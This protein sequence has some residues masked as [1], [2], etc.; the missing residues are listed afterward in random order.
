M[1]ETRNEKSKNSPSLLVVPFSASR[2][3]ALDSQNNIYNS[4]M[5][6][7]EGLR[8]GVHLY[9]SIYIIYAVWRSMYKLVRSFFIL[10]ILFVVHLLSTRRSIWLVVYHKLMVEEEDDVRN[11]ERQGVLIDR[12]IRIVLQ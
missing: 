11:R 12:I 9:Q 10:S 3:P 1:S 8:G 4:L 7:V 2:L 6:Q 5:F